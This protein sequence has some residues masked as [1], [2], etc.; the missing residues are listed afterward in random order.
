MF[1]GEFPIESKISHLPQKNCS[2]WPDISQRNTILC[3][4]YSKRFQL[5]SPDPSRVWAQKLTRLRLVFYCTVIPLVRQYAERCHLSRMLAFLLCCKLY[6][7]CNGC[8]ITGTGMYTKAETKTI[9][10]KNSWRRDV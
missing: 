5:L 1:W 2:D 8:H 4:F 6:E 7:K 9:V 10:S 3:Y